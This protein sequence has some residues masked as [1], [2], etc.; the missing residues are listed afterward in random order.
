MRVSGREA[1]LGK[2]DKEFCFRCPEFQWFGVSQL[3]CECS[4][5][6]TVKAAEDKTWAEA[7]PWNA[8]T[9]PNCEEP[10]KGSLP[11]KNRPLPEQGFSNFTPGKLA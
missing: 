2:R 5:L 3:G 4:D 8:A 9:A 11:G 1:S 10:T 7:I 6:G